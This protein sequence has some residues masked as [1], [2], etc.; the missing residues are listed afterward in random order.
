VGPHRSDAPHGGV[1]ISRDVEKITTGAKSPSKAQI[2]LNVQAAKTRIE[3]LFANEADLKSFG[4][5]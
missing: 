2:E 3:E 4:C 1:E 5:N